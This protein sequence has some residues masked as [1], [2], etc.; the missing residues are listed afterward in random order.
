MAEARILGWI[1][2]KRGHYTS[3]VSESM[4]ALQDMLIRDAIR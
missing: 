2:Q 3:L 1:S 4:I